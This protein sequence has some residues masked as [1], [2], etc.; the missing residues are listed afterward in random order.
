MID[1]KEGY[2]F[3]GERSRKSESIE[4]DLSILSRSWTSE[5]SNEQIEARIVLARRLKR[6]A[7]RKDASKAEAKRSKLSQ[8]VDEYASSEMQTAVLALLGAATCF[9]RA[10]KWEDAMRVLFAALEIVL[11]WKTEV[12]TRKAT[13]NDVPLLTC[14]KRLRGQGAI[15]KEEHQVLVTLIQS[16]RIKRKR[17]DVLQNAV[18]KLSDRF[19]VESPPPERIRELPISGRARLVS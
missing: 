19:L 8:K 1:P 10:D 15:E 5:A 2:T 17:L 7:V 18:R 13:T 4:K 14:V 12:Q 6:E 16:K 11:R 9:R 3:T